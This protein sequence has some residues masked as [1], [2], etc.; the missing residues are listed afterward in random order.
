MEIILIEHKHFIKKILTMNAAINEGGLFGTQKWS[1][2]FN[3]SH[4]GIFKMTCSLR[5]NK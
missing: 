4:Y 5:Q 3:E 1:A 2:V